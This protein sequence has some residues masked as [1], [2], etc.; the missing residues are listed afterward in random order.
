[1]VR[2]IFEKAVYLG[3]CIKEDGNYFF[4]SQKSPAGISVTIELKRTNS[5]KKFIE[6]IFDAYRDFDVSSE[7]MNWIDGTGHGINGAPYELEN[8]LNEIKW[9][10]NALC[11]LWYELEEIEYEAKSYK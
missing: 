11:R 2:K 6:I 7:T 10:K 1:M 5:M 3:W 9:C 4:L 8:V